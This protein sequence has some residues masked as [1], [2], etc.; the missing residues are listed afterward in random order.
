MNTFQ[1]DIEPLRKD[2]TI[3]TRSVA[4]LTTITSRKNKRLWNFRDNASNHSITSHSPRL[5]P[6][7][8]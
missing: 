3:N 5:A 4:G 7:T 2:F 8:P 1:K 6:P